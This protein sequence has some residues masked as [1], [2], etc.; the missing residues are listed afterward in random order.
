MDNLIDN[1]KPAL[2]WV[3]C[4]VA[5]NIHENINILGGIISVGYTIYKII[6]DLKKRK[7]DE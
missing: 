7:K 4:F 2:V 3:T 6:K 1:T 5:G